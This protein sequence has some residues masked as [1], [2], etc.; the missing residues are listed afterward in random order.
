MLS[1]WHRGLAIANAN[2]GQMLW[3]TV[4]YMMDRLQT[5]EVIKYFEINTLKAETS[6]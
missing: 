1:G 6:S 4:C 2:A 5:V 3:W